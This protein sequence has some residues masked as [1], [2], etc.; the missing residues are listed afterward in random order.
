MNDENSKYEATNLSKLPAS[1]SVKKRGNTYVIF[2]NGHE[3]IGGIVVCGTPLGDTQL[4]PYVEEPQDRNKTI[5]ALVAQQMSDALLVH[6]AKKPEYL[7]RDAFPP[8]FVP[9]G[10]EVLENKVFPCSKCNQI[11]ARLVFSWNTASTEEM[12]MVGK[13]F[14]LE[15]SVS[16]YPV[17]VLGAPDCDDNDIAKYLTF[18]IAPTK[19]AVY[20]EHPD[21]MNKRLIALDV[22]HC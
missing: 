14:E 4:Q 8:N 6:I 20:W 16:D 2:R 13:K 10:T 19:G 17:W 22:N 18:Q 3:E 5:V 21:D 9:A 11:V 15:A 1:I 7:R 12:E